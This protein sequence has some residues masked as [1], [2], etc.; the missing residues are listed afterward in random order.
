MRC[1][2]QQAEGLTYHSCRDGAVLLGK[3]PAPEGEL[4]SSNSVS[5]DRFD[6]WREYDA[7]C[8]PPCERCCMAA[9]VHAQKLRYG[10]VRIARPASR[11][12]FPLLG[13]P[14]SPGHPEPHKGMRY[15]SRQR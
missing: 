14:E 9:Q 4:I 8:G 15:A 3:E 13:F 2:S 11:L 5:Q 12:I 6:V 10:L 1:L 7:R